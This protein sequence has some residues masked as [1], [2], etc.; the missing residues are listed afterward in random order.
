MQ[1]ANI[2]LT[3]NVKSDKRKFELWLHGRTEVFIIQVI[4]IFRILEY[5]FYYFFDN[6]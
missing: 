2:G 6:I 5:K 3:E 1:T 4:M